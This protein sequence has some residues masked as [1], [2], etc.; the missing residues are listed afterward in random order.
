MGRGKGALSVT[1]DWATLPQNARKILGGH[2]DDRRLAFQKGS[3]SC[4]FSI[5]LM[6][7]DRCMALIQDHCKANGFPDS[8]L[9]VC[10][11][12]TNTLGYPVVNQWFLK[13][14]PLDLETPKVHIEA[15]N[16]FT[17]DW[18]LGQYEIDLTRALQAECPHMTHLNLTFKGSNP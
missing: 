11:I 1:F 5:P 12:L 13:L 10:R 14:V 8:W 15:P 17:R 2:L 6:A 9:Q 4:D 3:S 18:I 7:P 16:L